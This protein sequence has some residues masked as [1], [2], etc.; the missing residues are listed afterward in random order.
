MEYALF[1]GF[2]RIGGLYP[3]PEDAKQAI[4][5]VGIWNVCR[6]AALGGKLRIVGRETVIITKQ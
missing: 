3:T 2:D 1:R 6:V 5:G 4:D